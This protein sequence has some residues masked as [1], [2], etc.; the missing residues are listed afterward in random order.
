MEWELFFFFPKLTIRNS[1]DNNATPTPMPRPLF[2]P[3]HYTDDTPYNVYPPRP[4]LFKQKDCVPLMQ[5]DEF[6]QKIG[7]YFNDAH[8]L[9]KVSILLWLNNH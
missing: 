6:F 1:I 2:R 5:D 3:Q 4:P 9:L 8:D 7:K